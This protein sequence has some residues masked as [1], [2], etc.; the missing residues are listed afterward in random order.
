M[1]C[2]GG[3]SDVCALFGQR[4]TSEICQVCSSHARQDTAAKIAGFASESRKSHSFGPNTAAFG[5]KPS[6]WPDAI[7]CQ[8]RHGRDAKGLKQRLRAERPLSPTKNAFSHRVWTKIAKSFL[9]TIQT[10][11]VRPPE[12]TNRQTD[13]G[14]CIPTWRPRRG[15]PPVKLGLKFWIWEGHLSLQEMAGVE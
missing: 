4:T 6:T 8:H 1:V 5:N 14:G 9:L 10:K 7:P 2:G 13:S 11:P 15:S 3:V 12:S